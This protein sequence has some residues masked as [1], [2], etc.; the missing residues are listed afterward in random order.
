MGLRWMAIDKGLEWFFGGE[1]GKFGEN[2]L[3]FKK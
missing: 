2:S 1:R 3:K